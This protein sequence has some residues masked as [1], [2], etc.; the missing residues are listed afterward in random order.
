MKSRSSR[1]GLEPTKFCAGPTLA[2]LRGSWLR[3]GRADAE[4]RCTRSL[5]CRHPER[6]R[7]QHR[8]QWWAQRHG[9]MHAVPGP[10]AP[11][12]RDGF[13]SLRLTPD[14]ENAEQPISIFAGDRAWRTEGM[15]PWRC[16]HH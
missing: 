13:R 1:G 11:Q 3:P 15:T 2:G 8:R 4:L 12:I 10:D 5:T 9:V 14:I 16:A 6:P 7:L